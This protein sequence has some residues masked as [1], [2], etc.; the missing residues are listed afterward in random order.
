MRLIGV[1]M[2]L[3]LS[4]CSASMVT[5]RG[6]GNVNAPANE[7]RGGTIRY[8]TDGYQS[9]VDARRRNAY[10]KMRKYCGGSYRLISESMRGTSGIASTVGSNT[11]YASSSYNYIEFECDPKEN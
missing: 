2:V 4:G 1:I 7:G 8:L 11:F 10:K 9:A 6:P 3:L 5:K